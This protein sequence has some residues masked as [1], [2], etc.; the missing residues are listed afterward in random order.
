M[1]FT[2]SYNGVSSI[3]KSEAYI[4]KPYDPANPPPQLSPQSHA[5]IKYDA[6]WDTGATNCVISNKVISDCGLQPISMAIC[7]TANGQII[8]P[9]YLASIFLPNMVAFGSIRFTQGTIKDADILI[10]MDI[11]CSGDFA[12]TNLNRK[13]TFTYRYPSCDCLDFVKQP[14][15][16]QSQKPITTGPHV[17]RNDPC[18]CGSGKKYKRC[19]GLNS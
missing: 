3:L 1:S 10:G 9:V 12:V 16:G 14:T 4:G 5:A 8:T 6:I 15:P 2:V 13:T 19:H 17:G 7:H 11:I 18:P